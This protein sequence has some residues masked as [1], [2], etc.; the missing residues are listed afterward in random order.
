MGGILIFGAPDSREHH[1]DGLFW[2]LTWHQWH[3][4]VAIDDLRPGNVKINRAEFVPA[5]ISCE[6]FAKYCSGK[7]TTLAVDNRAAMRWFES[8]RCPLHP[9]DRCA[10]G[11]NLYMLKQNMKVR[12]T[13]IPTAEN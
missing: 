2:Q 3:K 11:L 8:A 6:T 7:Y 1:V 5:L 10:Q 4:I 13:W 9:F 12:I